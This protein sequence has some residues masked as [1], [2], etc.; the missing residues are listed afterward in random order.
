M[1]PYYVALKVLAYTLWCGLAL[2]GRHPALA[3]VI[4]RA[5]AWGMGRAAMGVLFGLG[6]WLLSTLVAI[7]LRELGADDLAMQAGAYLAV[8]VPVRV[9]EWGILA[10]LMLHRWDSFFILGGVGISLLADIPMI[11]A[12]GG[13]P[14]G[15][16][17]C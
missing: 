3:D 12:T 11:V 10:R 4:P 6:I 5:L 9:V 2:R 13:L 15:R 8:Y 1:L 14:I 7:G 17:M 16:F